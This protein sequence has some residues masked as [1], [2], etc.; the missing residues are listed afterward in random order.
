M[1]L[2]GYMTEF[3]EHNKDLSLR[4]SL[5]HQIT[6]HSTNLLILIL[7]SIHSDFFFVDVIYYSS[8]SCLQ[9]GTWVVRLTFH[10]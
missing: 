9:S 10:G 5:N 6:I 2:I 4:F 8:A 3:K 7:V 1:R